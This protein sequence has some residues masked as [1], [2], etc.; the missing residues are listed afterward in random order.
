MLFDKISLHRLVVFRLNR[1]AFSP[2]LTYHNR[3]IVTGFNQMVEDP[4]QDVKTAL[5]I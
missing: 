1:F 2:G 3:T 4:L 5:Q